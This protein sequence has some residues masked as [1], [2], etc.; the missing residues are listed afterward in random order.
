MVSSRSHIKTLSVVDSEPAGDTVFV[1]LPRLLVPLPSGATL[2]LLSRDLLVQSDL[3]GEVDPSV[4]FPPLDE[5]S[6][7]KIIKWKLNSTLDLI[8]NFPNKMFIDYISV[9]VN[10]EQQYIP[11][12]N[13]ENKFV[14]L[15]Y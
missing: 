10:T 8:F 11:F 7:T 12:Q 15:N 2:A 14:Y 13:V 5:L 1:L 3:S 9:I 4:N 6:A